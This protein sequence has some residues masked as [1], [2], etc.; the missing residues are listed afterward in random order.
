MQQDQTVP[1]VQHQT[2]AAHFEM[3]GPGWGWMLMLGKAECWF[4]RGPS[5]HLLGPFSEEGECG[6]AIEADA[7]KVRQTNDFGSRR[8]PAQDYRTLARRE[9]K[10]SHEPDWPVWV[11]AIPGEERTHVIVG[12][13]GV[14]GQSFRDAI[15]ASNEALSRKRDYAARG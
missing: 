7:N 6:R 14:E 1:A 12:P 11:V 4:G 15:D 3:P 13:G 9:L 5:G 10:Y 8:D 2:V